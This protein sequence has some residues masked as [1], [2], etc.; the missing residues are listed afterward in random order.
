MYRFDVFEKSGIA[1]QA[2]AIVFGIEA[3]LLSV[4][5][6]TEFEEYMITSGNADGS[7]EL[8]VFE[9]SPEEALA[10]LSKAGYVDDGLGAGARVQVPQEDFFPPRTAQR[11]GGGNNARPVG[12]QSR[13]APLVHP[14]SDDEGVLR[15]LPETTSL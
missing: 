11:R 8:L 15:G 5:T 2:N 10:A 4:S 13:L 6:V 14:G 12:T 7:P 1:P 9:G 3:G